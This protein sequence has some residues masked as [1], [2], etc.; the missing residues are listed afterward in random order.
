[1]STGFPGER[2]GKDI[3]GPSKGKTYII[4]ATVDYITKV[5]EAEPIKSQDAEMVVLIIF[6]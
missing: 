1:M 3:V 5:I 6:N 4:L 2:V